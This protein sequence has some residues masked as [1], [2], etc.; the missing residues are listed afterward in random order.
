[1]SACAIGA[2]LVEQPLPDIL[3]DGMRSIE[4]DGIRLLN[5]HNRK[6]T[7]AF[8]DREGGRTKLATRLELALKKLV[9]EFAAPEPEP[10]KIEASVPVR[11]KVR[12][13]QLWQTRG[14]DELNGY[15]FRVDE[16]TSRKG[17]A[18]ACSTV[19]RD[20]YSSYLHVR[21]ESGTQVCHGMSDG[22]FL[23]NFRLV[24]DMP[25]IP[26]KMPKIAVPVP[27]AGQ[28]WQTKGTDG[29]NG[30]IF[31]IDKIVS[32]VYLYRQPSADCTVVQEG[33][34]GALGMRRFPGD[35]V[36]FLLQHGYLADSFKPVNHAEYV[37][38][39]QVD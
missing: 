19:I 24:Q 28:Y 18:V 30:Y 25:S 15:V 22:Y 16:I 37:D 1:M 21:R 8:D 27:Q 39:I 34:S 6:A 20:G 4:P 3:P 36:S 38:R 17:S 26:D 12:V 10:A 33:F 23:G 31:R 14:A 29:E 9:M 2:G 13:G 32:G 7:D 35:H 11:T 5:F